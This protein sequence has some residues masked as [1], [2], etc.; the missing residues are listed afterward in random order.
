MILN[1]SYWAWFG[2]LYLLILTY[3]DLKNSNKVDTRYNYVMAGV[4][5]SLISH[6]E[7]II[8]RILVLF[9]VIILMAYFLNKYKAVGLADIQSLSWVFL[10][11]C[12]LNITF[13]LWFV[14]IFIGIT[15]FYIFLK[16]KLFK[17]ES[18]APFFPVILTS[19]ILNCCLFGLY[20]NLIG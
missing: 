6:V 2:T 17:Y 14:V 19:F 4:S 9:I 3:K 8:W 18:P 11:Y 20:S 12:I 13:L 15:L 16:V 5:L 1:I 7:F 10:G